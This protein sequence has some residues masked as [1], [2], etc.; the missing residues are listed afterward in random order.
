MPKTA[1]ALSYDYFTLHSSTGA[2][3]PKQLSRNM[4]TVFRLAARMYLCSLVPPFF[5]SSWIGPRI[6]TQNHLP[7][8]SLRFR[9]K[10]VEVKLAGFFQSLISLNISN[11]PP[12]PGVKNQIPKIGFTPPLPHTHHTH[13]SSIRQPIP[14]FF[15]L[16][17]LASAT[18]IYIPPLSPRPP[19]PLS[20]VPISPRLGVPVTDYKNEFFSRDYCILKGVKW[21]G[22]K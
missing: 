1:S 13:I 12:S 17:T 11:L 2:I 22:M 19:P 14:L 9:T 21:K 3:R 7:L 4:T 15:F 18:A 6:K 10:E 5:P 8:L 20:P 16:L